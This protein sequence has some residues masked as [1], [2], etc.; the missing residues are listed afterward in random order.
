VIFQL[1]GLTSQWLILNTST[2]AE[3][4]GCIATIFRIETPDCFAT[5]RFRD[6]D[7]P[8]ISFYLNPLIRQVGTELEVVFFAQD[9]IT[10]DQLEIEIIYDSYSTVRR[11][12]DCLLDN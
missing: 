1:N 3:V 9:P 11:L 4:D 2:T 10:P 7:V 8:E 6:K 12:Q 5:G